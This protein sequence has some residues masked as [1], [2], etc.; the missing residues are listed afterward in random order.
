MRVGNLGLCLYFH[1]LLTYIISICIM[2][3]WLYKDYVNQSAVFVLLFFFQDKFMFELDSVGCFAVFLKSLNNAERVFVRTGNQ[4][5]HLFFQPQHVMAA[6]A[7]I[8]IMDHCIY[9]SN[10]MSNNQWFY[11]ATVL[12]KSPAFYIFLLGKSSPLTLN[13]QV[14]Y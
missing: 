12:P 5:W 1:I 8:L 6:T 2:P 7:N 11:Q 3:G 10:K 4:S 14:Y 9:S 13:S